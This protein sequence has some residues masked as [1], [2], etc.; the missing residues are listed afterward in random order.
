MKSAPSLIDATVLQGSRNGNAR[1]RAFTL[2]E[3]LVVIAIIAIL[4]AMLLPALAIAKER[5]KRLQ[6]LNNVHQI[7]IALNS[8]SVD[9]N[10][11]LPQFTSGSGAAWSWDLPNA[12][13][14]IMLS[15]GLTK[16]ALY[17]PGTAPRF[18]D[19]Q[20]WSPPGTPVVGDCLWDYNNVAV[21]G[22]SGFHIIGYSLAINEFVK[23]VNA[24]F[25]DPTNQNKTLQAEKITFPGLGNTVLVGVSDRILIADAIL[26]VGSALPGY[27]KPQNNYLSIA[28]GFQQNGRTYPHTSPHIRGTLP[29]GGDAGYK[30]GHAEWHKFGTPTVMSPRTIGGAIFWW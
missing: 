9:S 14:D 11:K 17:D 7:E 19:R 29:A 8:Y 1:G 23:G 28:G 5:A 25:L 27:S 24:G 20:N 30:D 22:S 13:A 6:C 18:T 15:S 10:D 16:K 26:S 12:A 2:I 21:G 3:L 4:A